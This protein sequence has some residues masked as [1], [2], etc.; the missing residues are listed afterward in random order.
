M[1]KSKEEIKEFI[2][3]ADILLSDLDG[4]LAPSTAFRFVI[5]NYLKE[6]YK[7]PDF[8]FWALDSFFKY[9][10]QEKDAYSEGWQNYLKKFKIK[11]NQK[12]NLKPSLYSGVKEA[13]E[14]INKLNPNL[15]KL[16]VTETLPDI[17]EFYKNLL[18]YD[19]RYSLVENK[20]DLTQMISYAWDKYIVIGD[21][22]AD[23]LMI[24]ELKKQNKE[25]LGIFKYIFKKDKREG[26]DLYIRKWK[27]L[28][29]ILK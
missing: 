14:L 21:N 24:D 27:E 6:D 10:K 19:G 12:V 16:I 25:C 1:P 23:K 8:Y 13:H 26:F 3:T 4:T 7:N 22:I 11:S 20:G 29:E 18:N 9:L 2:K 28:E 15:T 5:Q 17:A